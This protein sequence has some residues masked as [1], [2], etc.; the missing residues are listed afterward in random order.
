[1]NRL[2]VEL[3]ELLYSWGVLSETDSW[4][5][6]LL[7]FVGVVFVAFLSYYLMK[8]VVIRVV[9]KVTLHTKASW[10]DM[11]FNDRVMKYACHL[12]PPVVIYL[13]MPLALSD[14][15]SWLAF[16][17]RV[18]LVY[19]LSVAIKLGSVF[20]NILYELSNRHEGLRN[21]PLKGLYQI[22]QVLL[23]FLG[24]ILIISVLIDRSPLTLLAGLGASA[25]ILMLVFKDTIMGF[26][27]GIQLSANDMLRP[28]DWIMMPRYGAD[29]TVIDVTLNTVKVRN[30]DN[31]ITTVPPYALVSDSFQNW[32]GMSESGG[33][34]I[35][36]AVNIDLNTVRFYSSEEVE[37]LVEHPLVGPVLKTVKTIEPVPTN[38]GLLR[39]YLLN[40][41]R[42]MPEAN[43][44]LTH[45][46]RQL[47][48][49]EKGVPL[50]VYFF[51]AKKVWVEYEQ[52]QS[53]LFDHILA[54]I[55]IFGL[56]VYQ[57]PSVICAENRLDGESA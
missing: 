54:V 52:V 53:D 45:L 40:Y 56:R 32:R 12:V 41:I 39:A 35:K 17:L 5:G 15:P 21:R 33:R 26:V 29:G 50:E 10:D 8:R 31:T 44:E 23:F 49:S 37:K 3:E 22:M 20:L 47:A 1:M 51:C 4:P 2:Q 19:F 9:R 42:Q 36:R 6:R 27:S 25:A 13:L 34:R 46:V 38:L 30:W 48:P 55:P 43:L 14:S 24:A 16:L 18:C 11:L 57:L 28:G 7:L